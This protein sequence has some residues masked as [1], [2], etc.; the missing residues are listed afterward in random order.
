[1]H[2]L[3]DLIR[4]TA[5]SYDEEGFE[6]S[7]GRHSHFYVDLKSTLLHPEGLDLLTGEVSSMIPSDV[8]GL[9]GI[10]LGGVPLCSVCAFRADLPYSIVRKE[11]KSH[12]MSDRLETSSRLSGG[13]EILPLE[14]VTTTGSSLAEGIEA[15]REAGFEVSRA[16]S[17]IDRQSGAADLLRDRD[18][19]LL[20][21]FTLDDLI[22]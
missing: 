20:N 17:V 22:R 6:L 9:G 15:W 21:L 2:D 8:D 7:S 12:G 13:D 18:V 1:M 19:D 5:F 16:I 4:R 11:S 14:D 10:A 3:I